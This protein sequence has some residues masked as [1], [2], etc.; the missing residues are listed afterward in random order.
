LA[1]GF[2]TW[3]D[4]LRAYPEAGNMESYVYDN[5]NHRLLAKLDANNFATFY[6]YDK[7]GN[8]IRVKRETEIGIVTLKEIRQSTVKRKRKSDGTY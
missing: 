4:D 6:E 3:F 1:N 7:E 8:L 2:K 5:I